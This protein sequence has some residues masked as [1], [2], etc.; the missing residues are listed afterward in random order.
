MD[1]AFVGGVMGFPDGEGPWYSLNRLELQTEE[2]YVTV[3]GDGKYQ[4]SV[5]HPETGFGLAVTINCPLSFLLLVSSAFP[6][7]ACKKEAHLAY[8][9]KSND[10]SIVAR[11]LATTHSAGEAIRCRKKGET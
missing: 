3:W 7:L 8:P 1:K 2:E 9:A 5:K 4:D 10:V 6:V 11:T